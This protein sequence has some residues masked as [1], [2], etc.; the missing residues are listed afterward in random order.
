LSFEGLHCQ[1]RCHCYLTWNAFLFDLECIPDDP[2]HHVFNCTIGISSMQCAPRFELRSDRVPKRYLSLELKS[3]V[4]WFCTINAISIAI[5]HC[6]LT[7]NAS[8]EDPLLP[9]C[10]CELPSCIE[11]AYIFHIKPTY[12]NTV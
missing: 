4:C 3:M 10:T 7:W 2:L 8:Q 5:G 6:Y 11:P 12:I 9:L 1:C